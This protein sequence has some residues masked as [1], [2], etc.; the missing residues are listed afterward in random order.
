MHHSIAMNAAAFEREKNRKAFIYTVIICTILLLLF[1]II[2]WQP[3]I[4]APPHMPEDL[5]EMNLGN[6][7]EGFGEN[8][9]LHKGDFAPAKQDIPKPQEAATKA[10]DQTNQPE[11]DKNADQNAAPVDQSEK[12]KNKK[13]DINKPA[14]QKPKPVNTPRI[15]VPKPQKPLITYNGPVTG[16]GNNATKDNDQ[17]GQGNDPKG[18]GDLGSPT[19]NPD[20]YGKDPHGRVGGVGPMVIDGDRKI[21]PNNYVFPGDLD[22]ATVYA[23]IKV[24]ED[25]NGTFVDF[26]KNST[27]RSHKYAA[28]ISE[29]LHHIKFNKADH[30]SPEVTVQFNFI[31][32]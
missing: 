4:V 8:Q 17:F 29:Y 22:K 20:S 18:K 32:K 13:I 26:G 24:D 3:G 11:P 19:G 31:V 12:K 25:G 21:L 2:K 9:P 10:Q 7:H 5:I 14:T 30:E 28:Q 1:F 16:K 23:I 15:V 6:D 27:S